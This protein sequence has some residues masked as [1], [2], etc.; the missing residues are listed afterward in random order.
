MLTDP[1]VIGAVTY[2]N[3]GT[4]QLVGASTASLELQ[5]LSAD[6]STRVGFIPLQGG[7]INAKSKMTISRSQ[8]NENKPVVS[9]RTLI[10]FDV[11]RPHLTTSKPIT[12]SAYLVT[13]LPQGG[14][15]FEIADQVCLVRSLALFLLIGETDQTTITALGTT[16]PPLDDTENTLCRILGGVA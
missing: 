15:P 7:T 3:T 4:D 1:L 5:D 13:S 8:S 12:M 6:G 2:G 11:V 14:T 16:T 10:R 9:D